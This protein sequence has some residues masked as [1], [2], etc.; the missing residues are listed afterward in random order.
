MTIVIRKTIKIKDVPQGERRFIFIGEGVTFDSQHPE[1][2]EIGN[3]IIQ[4]FL[5]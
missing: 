4:I 2:I 1:D 3:F 5:F